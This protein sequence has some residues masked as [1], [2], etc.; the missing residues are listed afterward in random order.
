ME[1]SFVFASIEKIFMQQES[2][3]VKRGAKQRNSF[4]GAAESRA[5][6]KLPEHVYAVCRCS[7]G[8]LSSGFTASSIHFKYS[9]LPASTATQRHSGTS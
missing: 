2:R 7:C 3:G 6:P 5:L 8:C 1:V 4:V 9:G